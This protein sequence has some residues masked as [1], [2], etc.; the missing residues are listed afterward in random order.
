MRASLASVQVLVCLKRDTHINQYNNEKIQYPENSSKMQLKIFTINCP[1]ETKIK[2][3][4][5]NLNSH[6]Y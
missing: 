4:Q 5:S 6:Q 1:A 3:H 2:F